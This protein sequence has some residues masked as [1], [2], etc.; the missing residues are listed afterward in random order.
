MSRSLICGCKLCGCVCEEHAHDHRAHHCLHH[1]KSNIV[2]WILSDA[3]A[4]VSLALFLGTIA[5]WAAI[6]GGYK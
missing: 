5:V 6:L 2:A 1:S 3:A 4:L